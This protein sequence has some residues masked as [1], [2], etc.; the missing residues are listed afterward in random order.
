MLTDLLLYIFIISTVFQLLLWLFVFSKLAFFK[1]NTPKTK[2]QNPPPVSIVICA[3]NE[4]A[5]LKNNLSIILQQKYPEF[6]VIIVDD[7]SDDDTQTVLQ[8]Y[9]YQFKNLRT[10]KIEHKTLPGKKGALA[11]GI[12]AAKYDWLLLTDADC[13]PLS[14]EWVSGM[15]SP[16]EAETE[17]VLGYAPYEKGT[18]FLNTFIRFE[19]VWTAVQYLSFALVG[20]PYMG[21][22]RNLLYRKKT[23][24][25]SGGFVSHQHIASGDDDLL[26]KKI[27]FKKNFKIF[28]SQKAFMY[29]KP[30]TQWNAYFTQKKRHLTT[31]T[32]YKIKHQIMLGAVSMSHFLHFVTAVLLLVLKISTMFVVIGIVVRSVVIWLFYGKILKRLHEESLVWYVP[33]LDACYIIFYLILAPFL[34][35]RTQNWR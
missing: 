30:K 2:Q 9:S 8:A 19:T 26:I 22:G 34:T 1:N 11:A 23:Y 5:N 7:A 12:E 17:I 6:E 15:M 25:K 21:V 3:R 13:Y 35:Y 28:L 27:I 4:T 20:Q 14:D 29:S 33:I 16:I 24:E 32:S 18:G 10:V 31:A